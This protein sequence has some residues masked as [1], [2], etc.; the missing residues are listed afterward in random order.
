M[1]FV[2]AKNPET[3]DWFFVGFDELGNSHFVNVLD[4]R[5]KRFQHIEAA[6]RV[7]EMVR[8]SEKYRLIIKPAHTH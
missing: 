6:E 3:G 4:V 8:L 2:R 5:A 7:L 1:F